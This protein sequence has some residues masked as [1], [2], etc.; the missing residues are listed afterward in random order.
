MSPPK[1][2]VMGLRITTEVRCKGPRVS[3]LSS[4]RRD[5]MVRHNNTWEAEAASWEEF[6]SVVML[7]VTSQ[8]EGHV[9]QPWELAFCVT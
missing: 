8:R 2:E 4:L 7:T 5:G 3:A 1:Q 9:F 6:E